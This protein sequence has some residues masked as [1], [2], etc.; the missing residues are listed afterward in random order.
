MSPVMITI[1]ESGRA[2][3]SVLENLVELKRIMSHMKDNLQYIELLDRTTIGP[4]YRL[5]GS[6]TMR[7]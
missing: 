6:G 5:L 3:I 1:G 4:H 2:L 7:L